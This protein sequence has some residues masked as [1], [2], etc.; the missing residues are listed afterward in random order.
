MKGKYW[1]HVPTKTPGAK[2]MG[3]LPSLSDAKKPL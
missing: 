1:W 2:L 3:P